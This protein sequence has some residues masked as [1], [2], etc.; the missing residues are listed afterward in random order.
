MRECAAYQQGLGARLELD[1]RA[2]S[3]IAAGCGDVSDVD[4]S[5]A[6]NLPEALRIELIAQ[7]AQRCS[8][9]GFGVGGENA[10]VFVVSLRK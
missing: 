4:D 9:Q 10:G 6:V 3:E 8:D 7:L 5:A 2:A 1:Q